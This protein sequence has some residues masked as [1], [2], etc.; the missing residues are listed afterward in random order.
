MNDD[1]DDLDAD[2]DRLLSHM[3]INHHRHRWIH[4][5]TMRLER[6]SGTNYNRNDAQISEA[7]LRM[8]ILMIL[9]L[10]VCFFNTQFAIIV[11]AGSIQRQ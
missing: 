11:T 4:T 1:F 6:D 7:G 8:M 9:M 3:T 5:E 2:R 10:I